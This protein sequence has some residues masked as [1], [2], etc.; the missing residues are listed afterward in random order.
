MPT[1]E[2][3]RRLRTGTGVPVVRL[4]RTLYDTSRRVL[5]V[6]DFVLAG[7]RHVLVYEVPAG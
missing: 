7:D 6:S 1:P 2:E 4:L 3:A 5:E